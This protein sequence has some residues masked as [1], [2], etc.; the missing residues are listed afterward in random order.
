MDEQS[1][2][3]KIPHYLD[4]GRLLM[5]MPLSEVLPALLVFG[6]FMLVNYMMTG[7]V[8]GLVIFFATRQLRQGKGDNFIPLMLFWYA[9][10]FAN[11]YGLFKNTPSSDKRYWLN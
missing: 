4:Q 10:A 11:K 6:L 5:G 3:Y 2:F 7:L 9:P 1:T 8:I